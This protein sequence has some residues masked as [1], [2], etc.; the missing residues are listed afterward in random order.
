MPKTAERAFP[1]CPKRLALTASDRSGVFALADW[2]GDGSKPEMIVSRLRA[3]L[4]TEVVA[5]AN[6]RS[7][8]RAMVADLAQRY[9]AQPNAL[10]RSNAIY[11]ER[12]SRIVEAIRQ[13]T[14]ALRKPAAMWLDEEACYLVELKLGLTTATPEQMAPT[15]LNRERR[16]R[17][18][19]GADFAAYE[20]WPLVFP[21]D[22]TEDDLSPRVLAEFSLWNAARLRLMPDR[23]RIQTMP[24]RNAPK[25][26]FTDVLDPRL[27]N[28]WGNPGPPIKQLPSSTQL[29]WQGRWVLILSGPVPSVASNTVDSTTS[30]V[31]LTGQIDSFDPVQT[32]STAGRFFY[33]RAHGLEASIDRERPLGKEL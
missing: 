19:Y 31:I 18:R 8:V 2:M 26:A 33:I 17:K 16:L 28:P 7:R 24:L 13:S 5:K 1:P 21:P 6:R 4:P 23:L 10:P 32:D 11:N 27:P 22:T 25:T 30:R 20:T 9:D 14:S 3:N 12:E 29:L 15:R